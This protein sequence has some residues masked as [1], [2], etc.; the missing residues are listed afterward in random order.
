MKKIVFGLLLTMGMLN[1]QNNLVFNQV[2]LLELSTSTP[3]V[4]PEGKV[5]K[6]EGFNTG[7]NVVGTC[8]IVDNSIYFL[9]TANAFPSPTWLPENSE[10]K[11]GSCNQTS[12]SSVSKISVLEFNVVPTSS[13]TG[14]GTGG[15]SVSSDGLIFSQMINE[16]IIIQRTSSSGT[17]LYSFDIPAG[18]IWKLRSLTHRYWNENNTYY[19]DQYVEG[20]V[21]I[22]VNGEPFV[23]IGP[24]STS[25]NTY[26]VFLKEGSYDIAWY[27]NDY[28]DLSG[29]RIF[30]QAIEYRIP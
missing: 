19:Q 8:I 12:S 16:A 25:G 9:G 14:S 10:I 27:S 21:Y 17:V 15:G 26:E 23:D 3:V 2:L 4:V 11:R 7:G 1:A 28:T 6:I 30:L 13:G 24:Y 5:W 22:S 18:H 29:N 20:F